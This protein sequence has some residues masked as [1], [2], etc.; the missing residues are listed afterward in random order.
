ME[1]IKRQTIFFKINYT[2]LYIVAASFYLCRYIFLPIAIL[3]LALAIVEGNWK[4]RYNTLKTNKLLLYAALFLGFF[5]CY[6]ISPFFSDNIGRAISSWEYKIWFLVCPICILPLVP[7]LSQTQFKRMF[8][9]YLCVILVMAICSLIQS[10]YL[11]QTTHKIYHLYY[12]HASTL[13]LSSFRHPSYCSLYEII[14]WIIAAH[15]LLRKKQHTLSTPTTI[16]CWATLVV[17]SVHI[18]FLQS[19]IGFL[20]FGIA[21]FIYLGIALKRRTN[22][23][24]MIA[25]IVGIIAGFG[26]FMAKNYGRETKDCDNRF[27]NSIT[28]FQTD[29]KKNPTEST[30]IRIALW[31]NSWEIGREHWFLGVGAGDVKELMLNKAKEHN[32][33]YIASG[34]F[35]CHNQYLQLWLC[36]GLPGL[37]LFLAILA[38]SF[39]YVC[40]QKMLPM[41][42]I[43]FAFATNLLVECMLELVAGTCAIPI[44]LTLMVGICQTMRYHDNREVRASVSGE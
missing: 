1:E 11:W 36:V 23:F 12:Q 9:V 4:E 19:K 26:A 6:L 20:T 17:L 31:H 5:F 44:V 15:L 18:Y 3:W 43:T 25:V 40:R 21:F 16:L 29:D 24:V 38:C 30:S 13:P 2:L 28:S 41:I 35:N 33:K 10:F 22:I 42:L 8:I 39:V 14:A 37:L 34:D 27:A 32:Y 7:K